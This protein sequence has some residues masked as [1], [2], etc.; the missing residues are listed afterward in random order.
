MAA[1]GIGVQ[2]DTSFE[3]YFVPSFKI[4]RAHLGS[5]GAPV[6]LQHLPAIEE[7]HLNQARVP[8]ESL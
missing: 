2:R 4:E 1:L 5:G 6:A 8:S 3:T 7:T